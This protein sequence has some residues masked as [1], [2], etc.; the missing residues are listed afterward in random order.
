MSEFL[1]IGFI[2]LTL[3]FQVLTGIVEMDWFG[4]AGTMQT[5]LRPEVVES[6]LPV[7]GG[8]V[9]FVNQSKVWIGAFWD[10]LWFD[11]PFFTG[12]YIIVRYFCFPFSIG[13]IYGFI[14]SAIGVI[15]R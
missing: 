5:L 9:T 14:K 2:T 11:Y 1:I 3:I 6:T 12:P 4:L 10:I 15:R 13:I 7:I 8:S